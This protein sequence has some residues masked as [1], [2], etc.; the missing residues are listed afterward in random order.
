MRH[1]STQ[2][3]N[4]LDAE[5][6]K[7]RIAAV[8]TIVDSFRFSLPHPHDFSPSTADVCWIPEVRKIIIDGTDQEF[9]D[10]KSDLRSRIPGLSAAWLEERRKFFLQHLPQDSPNLEHFSL[11]TTLFDCMRC[12]KYGLRI[13]EAVSH[14]CYSYRH[15][16]ENEADFASAASASTFYIHAGSPWD[17]RYS[18]YQYSVERST[19]VREVVVECGQDPD[20]VT[21]QEMKRKHHRF[22]RFDLGGK[23][24][25]LDWLEAVS[26]GARLLDGPVPHLG[27]PA[28]LSIS[29]GAAIYLVG[30]CGLKNYRSM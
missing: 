1:E 23:I 29:V 18:K 9:R 16:K 13:E 14:G 20:T 8:K 24:S 17:S 22:A 26:F 25:V 27:R 7:G 3:R 30:S 5:R 11:A 12:R 21:I 19:F 6:C 10:C 28:R 15:A 2:L 4:Q